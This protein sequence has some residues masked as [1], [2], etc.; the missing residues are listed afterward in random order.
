[1][2]E[3]KL[4]SPLLDGFSMGSPISTHDGVVC[5]PAMKENSDNRYI[6][7]KIS[8]PASQVQLDALLLTGAYDD[9][10]DAMDY[11]K[12][13][14]DGVEK[15]AMLLNKLSRLEGF[16]P[17]DSWQVE[18]MDENRLGYEFYLV[19]AYKR[20]LERYLQKHPMTHL[21][22]VNLGVDLCAALAIARRAGYLYVDLKPS[23]VFRSSGKEFRIG[24][25]GFAELASLKYATLPSKYRSA[26]TPPEMQDAL[27]GVNT[28][29][30]T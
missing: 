14:A 20:S 16:L 18:P 26:Y 17:Y 5:Y 7:K 9:P 10:G 15:E 1:M 6:V 27:G 23:N 8:I 30:D 2:S 19:S 13:I 11:F 29:A 12:S 4:I 24:D 22:A 28:T 25:L 3:P 21:G